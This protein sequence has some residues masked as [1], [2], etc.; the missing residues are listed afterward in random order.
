MNIAIGSLRTGHFNLANVC[1]LLG[2]A[3]LT[4]EEFSSG[5]QSTMKT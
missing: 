3:L 5:R 1:I 2:I 4:I